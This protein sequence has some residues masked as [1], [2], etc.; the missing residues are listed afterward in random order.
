MQKSI[1]LRTKVYLNLM[2]IVTQ[3]IFPNVPFSHGLYLMGRVRRGTV[4]SL[5]TKM[6]LYVHMSTKYYHNS[7]IFENHLKRGIHYPES[8][9]KPWVYNEDQDKRWWQ[10]TTEW[11]YIGGCSIYAAHRVGPLQ[12]S[13][14]AF[15]FT[16]HTVNCDH[17]EQRRD[18]EF[19]FCQFLPI[20]NK[21]H[22]F[23]NR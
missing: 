23:I 22:F 10:M 3:C 11:F 14:C 12:P 13:S 4:S 8:R 2:T 17:S 19:S 1:P 20:F 6:G 9:A 18:R 5:N 21:E 15:V 16:N 7:I